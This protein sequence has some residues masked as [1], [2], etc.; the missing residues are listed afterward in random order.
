MLEQAL[1]QKVILQIM[2][3]IFFFFFFGGKRK[4]AFTQEASNLGRWWAGV[5]RPPLS[6]WLGDR[7]LKVECQSAPATLWRLA[8]QWSGHVISMWIHILWVPGSPAPAQGRQSRMVL[9]PGSHSLKTSYDVSTRD[10][11]T[12]R[13]Q[14]ACRWVRQQGGKVVCKWIKERGEEGRVEAG[15]IWRPSL[16]DKRFILPGQYSLFKAEI[17]TLKKMIDICQHSGEYIFLSS[18]THLTNW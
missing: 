3:D 2:K 7:K 8:L 10:I 5:L 18:H 12:Q 9:A 13:N 14:P 15:G 1:M 16:N 6:C 4:G 11:S 17:K